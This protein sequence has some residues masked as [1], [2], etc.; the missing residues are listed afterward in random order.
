MHVAS[1]HE[2]KS[3]KTIDEYISR[4]L[5]KKAEMPDITFTL[6]QENHFLEVEYID[7]RVN[8]YNILE[9]F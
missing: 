3:I 2:I 4:R 6:S 7:R 5:V 1:D 8:N 9:I